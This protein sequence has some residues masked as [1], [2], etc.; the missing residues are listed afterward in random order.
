MADLSTGQD[1]SGVPPILATPILGIAPVPRLVRP[2][3]LLPEWQTE[4]EA[5]CEARRSGKPRG[6]ITGLPTV[7]RELG[8]YVPPGLTIVH[9]APGVGKT[10]MGLQIAAACSSPALYVTCEMAT[11]EL[12]RR[13]VAR[14]TSTF[15]GKLRTGELAPAAMLA[16][17]ERA[18]ATAR[19]LVLADATL[20]PATSEFLY[21][22]AEVVKGPSDHVLLVVDSIHTWAESVAPESPEYDALNVGL[23]SLRAIAARLSCPILVIAERNRLS[24]AKG[25]LSAGAGTRKLEY[26]AEAVLDLAR[27]EDA[28]EDAMG[29]IDVT[30][31]IAKNRNGPPG[32]KIPL[33]FH[34]AL[35]RF[36][37]A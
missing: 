2:R 21:T 31:K 29:E 34:G 37:E 11:L 6:P 19:D 17:A 9:A 18:V 4:A 32:R 15:L 28:R 24:M 7:D 5:A 1:S 36:R 16:L 8:G 14:T 23:A 26:G 13:V 25:G 35:Q 10:A 12:L 33:K 30:L 27:D 20:A 22:S 3:D